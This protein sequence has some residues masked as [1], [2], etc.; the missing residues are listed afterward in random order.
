M[1]LPARLFN[2]L[3]MFLDVIAWQTFGPCAF[4]GEGVCEKRP[5][6]LLQ[7]TQAHFGCIVG[8]QR[9]E[10]Q[11]RSEGEHGDKTTPRSGT[12][13]MDELWRSQDPQAQWHA[14]PS[15]TSA[16]RCRAQT[17]PQQLMGA[18]SC[19]PAWRA[20]TADEECQRVGT[21]ASLP[22][23]HP[24]RCSSSRRPPKVLQCRRQDLVSG[25]P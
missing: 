2:N 8:A 15:C 18:L 7:Q 25:A 17:P 24:A 4:G 5:T 13:R 23:W 1:F 22:R 11:R 14:P 3:L 9:N 6:N 16:G 19:I 20:L 12:T 10:G 21:T